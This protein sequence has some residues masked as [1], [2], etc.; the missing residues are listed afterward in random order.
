[1]HGDLLRSSKDELSRLQLL[2]CAAIVA[3]GYCDV[4]NDQ[5]LNQNQLVL[6]S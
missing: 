1:M 5:K 6:N 2:I 4:T 3:H